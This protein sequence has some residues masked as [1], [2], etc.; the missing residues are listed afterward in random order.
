MITVPLH[1]WF[2]HRICLL[3]LLLLLFRFIFEI[4]ISIT[5]AQNLHCHIKICIYNIKASLPLILKFA[6][7]FSYFQTTCITM[8]AILMLTW[9]PYQLYRYVWWPELKKSAELNV[10]C[11]NEITYHKLY[12]FSYKCMTWK[13]TKCP[14]AI[15][16]IV[17]DLE[18][19]N[20]RRKRVRICVMF[21]RNLMKIFQFVPGRNSSHLQ[22]FL[23]SE[24]SW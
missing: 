8:C 1:R 3:L 23:S 14:T 5:L 21:V 20:L 10:K 18:V 11:S 22:T 13:R 17:S 12:N 4:S 19:Q 7:V 16:Q 9:R 24:L 2:V 6:S 15:V